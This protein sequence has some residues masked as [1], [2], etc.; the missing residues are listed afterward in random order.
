M[1]TFLAV[2]TVFSPITGLSY[3]LIIVVLQ[4]LIVFLYRLQ[5]YCVHGFIMMSALFKA[6]L[7]FSATNHLFTS[8]F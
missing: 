7:K 2:L 5:V 3:I 1:I 6:I 4:E 8:L